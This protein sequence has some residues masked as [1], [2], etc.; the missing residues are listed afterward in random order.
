MSDSAV[1]LPSELER[2]FDLKIIPMCVDVKGKTY[3]NYLDGREI[4]S[5]EFYDILR[6]GVVTKTSMINP[7]AFIE[8]M[9]PFLKE[10]YDILYIG[11]SS[12]LSGTFNSANIAKEELQQIYEDRQIVLI[13]SLCASL[14][15]GLLVSYACKLKQAGKSLEEVALFVEENKLN[16]CH[17]FTVGDLNHLRRGGRLSYAKALLGTVLR[18]KP[19][20]QVNKEGKLVQTGSTRGRKQSIEKMFARMKET[21]V[22]PKN[23]IVYIS[24]GDCLEEALELKREIIKELHVQ[25]VLI[26]YIGPVIGSH[27]GLGTL[28]IFYLGNDRIL[29]YK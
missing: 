16:I 18:I 20:L 22:D 26:N 6:K 13:D 29:P 25:E 2:E 15:Q 12:A 4:S 5:K 11:F 14:G 21:I 17:L 24:H 7:E 10:G 9:D 3:F 28:A 27:S 8:F 1:D 19:I 23:Q